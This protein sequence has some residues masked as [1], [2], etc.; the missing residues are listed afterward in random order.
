MVLLSF[1]MVYLHAAIGAEKSISL[2]TSVW[3]F[4]KF[5][6]RYTENFA[7]QLA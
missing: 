3:I 6:D 4:F 7:K 5:W 2:V 1:L